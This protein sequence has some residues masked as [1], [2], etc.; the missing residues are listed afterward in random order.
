VAAIE[1]ISLNP[2][3][4]ARIAGGGDRLGARILWASQ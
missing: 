4:R 2:A 3:H 1:L